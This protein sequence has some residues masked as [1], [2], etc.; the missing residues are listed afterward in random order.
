MNNNARYILDFQI[1]PQLLADVGSDYVKNCLIEKNRFVFRVFD[2][3]LAKLNDQAHS[4]HTPDQFEVSQYTLSSSQKLLY[5]RLPDAADR[6]MLWC[7]AYCITFTQ[8]G[9]DIRDV[10]FF[11]VEKSTRGT[12]CIGTMTTDGDH[13]NYG[14]AHPSEE[15]N[16]NA[17]FSVAFG[18]SFR[19]IEWDLP[20]IADLF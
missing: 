4:G 14:I 2:T 19:D 1:M 18:R 5:I 6:S 20:V 15:D 17:V 13:I 7:T 10:Q 8:T 16:I 11:T 9:D 12:G 3:F